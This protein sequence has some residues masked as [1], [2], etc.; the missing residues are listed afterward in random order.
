MVHLHRKVLRASTAEPTAAWAALV[1]LSRMAKEA[2][3]SIGVRMSSDMA[4]VEILRV[5]EDLRN[6]GHGTRVMHA[7]GNWGDKYRTSIRLV[8][9]PSYGAMDPIRLM[10]FY[11]RLGYRQLSGAPNGTLMRE[12]GCTQIVQLGW[13]Q[14]VSNRS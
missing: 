7:L 3:V 6:Q 10:A 5:R 9:D 2:G 11:H 14:Q 4:V 12:P 1:T 8:A 13:R